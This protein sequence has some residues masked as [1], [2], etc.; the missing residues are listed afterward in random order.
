LDLYGWP[1]VTRSVGH[2]YLYKTKPNAIFG[3]KHPVSGNINANAEDCNS[4]PCH[5]PGL[6]ELDKSLPVLIA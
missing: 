6:R 4:V 3:E 5:R 1:Q 2:I